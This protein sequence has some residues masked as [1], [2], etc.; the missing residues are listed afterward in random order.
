MFQVDVLVWSRETGLLKF[1]NNP[2]H[3]RFWKLNDLILIWLFIESFWSRCPLWWTWCC[4]PQCHQGGLLF[5][6]LHNKLSFHEGYMDLWLGLWQICHIFQEDRCPA[7]IVCISKSKEPWTQI[8]SSSQS[9][10]PITHSLTSKKSGNRS[11]EI[12]KQLSSS[13]QLWAFAAS[14]FHIMVSW[15]LLPVW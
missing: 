5:T 2:Q 12:L 4:A 3:F 14:I 1:I 13:K 8:F 9:Q 6:G 15:G 11:G 7:G 10:W